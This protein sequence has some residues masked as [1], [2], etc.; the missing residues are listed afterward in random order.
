[1]GKRW[2]RRLGPTSGLLLI[3]GMPSSVSFSFGLIPESISNFGVFMAPPLII[4]SFASIIYT[5]L[6]NNGLT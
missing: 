2:S 4:N 3:T 1:M 6:D 5:L